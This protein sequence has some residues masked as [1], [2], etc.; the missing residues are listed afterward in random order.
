MDLDG[1][2]SREELGELEEGETI[3]RIYCIKK[4]L[5]PTKNALI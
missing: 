5:F 1:K 2:E 4:N 3:I